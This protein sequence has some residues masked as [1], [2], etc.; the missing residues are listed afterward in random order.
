MTIYTRTKNWS[1]LMVVLML[2]SMASGSA[3]PV[4]LLDE[5]TE[6]PTETPTPTLTESPTENPTDTPTDTPTG[7][8]TPTDT[9][10]PTL[11]NM[12]TDTAT[13][14]PTSTPSA[15][16]TPITPYLSAPACVGEH[17]HSDFHTL[18][19][20]VDGCHYDHE[21]GQYPFTQAVANA[22]PGFDLQALIGGVGVGHTNPSSEMENHHKHGGMKWDVT[23]SHTKGCTGGIGA[24]TGVNAL[25]LQYHAFGDYSIEFESRIHSALA[26]LR[27][28]RTA[29]PTDYG[30]V[31]VNQ[32]QDYG[33]RITPYQGTILQYP[34]TPNPAYP[35]PNVPYFS[36]SCLGNVPQC[37][38]SIAYV[39]Q[40]NA[41]AFSTWF[42]NGFP[43]I[44][45]GSP[46]FGI[47]LRV[48]DNYQLL[49][50]S[51]LTY[52]FTFA[53]LCSSDGGLTYAALAGCRY[54][55]ST[56]RVHGVRG[57]IPASWDNLVSF[58]SNPTLGRITAEGFV[59]RYGTLNVACA[60][61]GI[62]CHPIKM[63]NAFTGKYISQFALVAGKASQAPE[64][65]PERDFCFTSAGVLIGC[66]SPGAI[67]SG[68]IRAGN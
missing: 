67:S 14:T 35:S 29:N 48:R 6:T 36:V 10:E 59:T 38:P 3:S 33:Q 28:C 2:A 16:P 63:V 45:I 52:P 7:T 42:S 37:R 56:T 11:T 60:E 57:E 61:P 26:L 24:P 8:V 18:W 21:H 25:V 5:L 50:Y 46:L 34:D 13:N 53:W 19:N 9:P 43:N 23:L 44:Q 1:G 40:R 30:Y 17:D 32:F 20:S 15:T 54:N 65:L 47:E 12:P 66:D 39:F 58:D 51:D 27:Q 41:D 4:T 55:N 49:N 22:F 68:W 62:D 64:N 31:F